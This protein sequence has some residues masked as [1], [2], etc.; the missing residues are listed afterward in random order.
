MAYS[1][2]QQRTAV[3]ILLQHG[4]VPSSCIYNFKQLYNSVYVG[5]YH[6]FLPSFWRVYSRFLHAVVFMTRYYSRLVGGDFCIMLCMYRYIFILLWKIQSIYNQ[7]VKLGT[8]NYT[9]LAVVVV[10]MYAYPCRLL[11]FNQDSGDNNILCISISKCKALSCR[12]I[13]F[14]V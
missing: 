5:Y 4:E 2:Y 14:L 10:D 11:S 8:F 6:H 7:A 13:M 9:V 1:H 3:I 12:G